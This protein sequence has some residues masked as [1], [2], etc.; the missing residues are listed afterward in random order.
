MK[1]PNPE[2]GEPYKRGEVLPTGRIFWSYQSGVSA[3]TRDRDGYFYISSVDPDEF[4][5]RQRK[6]RKK[7]GGRDRGKERE[8]RLSR[9]F[10]KRM[11][12]DNGEPFKITDGPNDEG[13]YFLAYNIRYQSKIHPG[14]CNETWTTLEKVNHEK[15]RRSQNS[16]QKYHDGKKLVEEGVLFLRTDPSTGKPFEF[17]VRRDDG[18]TFKNYDYRNSNDDGEIREVWIAESAFHKLCINRANTRIKRKCKADGIPYN[19]DTD[20]LQS[21]FPQDGKCPVFG[22]DLLWG[23]QESDQDAS[24]SLDRFDP[25]GGYVKGNVTWISNRANILKRDSTVDEIG[26]L[27]AWMK[28][29]P[30]KSQS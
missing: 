27:H 26:A 10:P 24:P 12:P 4:K 22:S 9:K 17:G 14:F 23:N 28:P 30:S 25:K 11:N 13:L 1:K 19:L 16:S 21:I 7:E 6:E 18:L 2:T 8:E 29:F 15:R 3:T 20:Y 5:E